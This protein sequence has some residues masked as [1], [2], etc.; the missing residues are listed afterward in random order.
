MIFSFVHKRNLYYAFTSSSD[1]SG[2]VTEIIRK[3]INLDKHVTWPS[4]AEWRASIPADA[5]RVGRY[6]YSYNGK[7]YSVAVLDSGHALEI[8]RGDITFPHGSDATPTRWGSLAD[9]KAS[10]PNG[11]VPIEVAPKVKEQANSN[12]PILNMFRKQKVYSNLSYGPQQ[13]QINE[14]RHKI[15]YYKLRLEEYKQ[16]PISNSDYIKGAEITIEREQKYLDKCKQYDEGKYK[17][18]AHLVGTPSIYVMKNGTL[19]AMI[20][21]NKHGVVRVYIGPTELKTPEEFGIDASC[22]FYRMDRDTFTLTPI[23]P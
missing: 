13:R 23:T 15:R 20:H 17:F 18:K 19:R 12:D 4:V 9:W 7:V 22:Q 1:E 10:W 21:N 14:A 11:A 2:S 16:N 5:V 3:G 6:S 8:R